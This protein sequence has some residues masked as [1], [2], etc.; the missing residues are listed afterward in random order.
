[1]LRVPGATGRDLELVLFPWHSPGAFSSHTNS[2]GPA[3]TTCDLQTS[4]LTSI[5]SFNQS[6][7][8]QVA[9]ISTCVTVQETEARS[10][11]QDHTA[12]NR[13]VYTV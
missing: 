10:F 6:P 13:Q 5:N 12:P 4:I 1:M 9:F 3:H 8:I 2:W 11:A 7:L